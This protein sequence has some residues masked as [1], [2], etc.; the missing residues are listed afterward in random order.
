MTIKKSS[1]GGKGWKGQYIVYEGNSG[2]SDLVELSDSQ[3]ALIYE[4][5][6]KRYTD[7]LAFKVVN[8]KSIPH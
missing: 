4:G 3:I 8:I 7:G 6:E 2:Y 5:G 1:D